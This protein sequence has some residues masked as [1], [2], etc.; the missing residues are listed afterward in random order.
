MFLAWLAEHAT[1]PG[2][3][4]LRRVHGLVPLTGHSARTTAWQLAEQFQVSART[5]GELL[6]AVAQD[7]RRTVIVL[8]DLHASTEPAAIEE[9]VCEL[10]ACAHVRVIVETRQPSTTLLAQAPAVMDL[11]DPQWTDPDRHAV[12]AATAPTAANDAE[13][14][15]AAPDLHA[16]I[17]LEDPASVCV[18]DPLGVTA[19]YESTDNPHG[20]LRAAWLRAGASLTRP[21]SPA[22]RACVLWAALGD[23]ADPR[24]R[25]SLTT[26]AQDAGW[27]VR[28][29]RVR[30]D[31]TPPWPGPVQAMSAGAVDQHNSLAVL[32]HQ[33]V[34]RLLDADSGHPQGRLAHT[35]T[36]ASALTVTQDG[37]V[38]ILGAGGH[39][40]LHDS[41]TTTHPSGLAGLM[42]QGPSTWERLLREAQSGAPITAL[43]SA[44]DQ[45]AAGGLDGTVRVL[46]WNSSGVER[47][48]TV[49]HDGAVTAVAMVS[50]AG[51]ALAYSGGQDGRVR[52]WARDQDPLATA[53]AERD[54][55]VVALAA[56]PAHSGVAL[57]IGWADG[58]V[59][60]TVT[61][62]DS[63]TLHRSFRPG[64]PVR[65]L[66][67]LPAGDLMIG[68][69][70]SLICLEPR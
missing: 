13:P 54:C 18:A 32:D 4:T 48:S 9:L 42:D 47:H 34:V 46:A 17:D 38:I 45:L 3:E 68:T 62:P 57:A 15:P 39:L 19:S 29:N 25:G 10:A 11:T 49:L 7:Q 59:E 37:A 36:E 30:G 8:P 21:Q 12:W 50:T 20:G 26:L 28:W 69:D 64:P 24:L 31:I 14:A 35:A 61:G 27:K 44:S 58:L 33:G 6:A 16:P 53:V 5:P 56:A 67:L 22:A 41:P 66:S 51:S 40:S 2:T 55:A 70:E 63:A 23:A 43:A 52:L 1:E 65:A 60:H